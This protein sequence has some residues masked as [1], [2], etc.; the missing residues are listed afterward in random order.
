[1]QRSTPSPTRQTYQ[2]QSRTAAATAK[3]TAKPTPDAQ[4]ERAKEQAFRLFDNEWAAKQNALR[5][6]KQDLDYQIKNSTGPTQTQ[7]KQ[8]LTQWQKEKGQADRDHNAARTSLK[9]EWGQ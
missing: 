8:K 9:K 1:R 3:P 2:S 7:W 6:E 4:R 5:A